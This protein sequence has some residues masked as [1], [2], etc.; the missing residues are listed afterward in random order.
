LPRSTL[1]AA[2]GWLA[3]GAPFERWF[4]LYIQGLF[5]QIT[6]QVACNGLHSVNERCSRWLLLTMIGSTR[7]SSL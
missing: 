3:E 5:S 1:A 6:Q 4:Q 7:M 2:R